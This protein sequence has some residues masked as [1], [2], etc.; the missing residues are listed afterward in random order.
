MGA[1]SGKTREDLEAQ[2]GRP[3]AILGSSDFQRMQ[4]DAL[5][6]EPTEITEKQYMDALE[7]LPPMKWGKWLGV[8]S[9]RMCEF[10]SG[11]VTNIYAKCGDRYWT[12]LDNAYMSG[13]DIA[14]KVGRAMQ[15]TQH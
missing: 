9:F 6:T 13:E 4:E 11:N 10:Y 3:M 12:F 2:Y 15:K 7:V 8:E 14:H 1:Y 5:R